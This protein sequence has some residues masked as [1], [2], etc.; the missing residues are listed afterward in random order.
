VNEHGNFDLFG[1]GHGIRHFLCLPWHLTAWSG[2]F[3]EDNA[4]GLLEGLPLLCLPLTMLWWERRL[5][6]LL[7]L[8]AC[9]LVAGTFLWFRQAQYLR[10]LLP[11]VP[12]MALLA[13]INAGAV[14]A[15]IGTS[16]RSRA[17]VATVAL[18][19]GLCWFQGTRW[20]AAKKNAMHGYPCLLVFGLESSEE[21]LRSVLAEYDPLRYLAAQSDEHATRVLAYPRH[22]RL[23]GG[24]CEFYYRAV[25][26][27]P[28][29]LLG[30]RKISLA[31]GTE[32]AKALAATSIDYLLLTYDYEYEVDPQYPGALMDAP[33]LD[34][35][36]RLIMTR[37]SWDHRR[38]CLYQF[39]R[40]AVDRLSRP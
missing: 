17:R 24:N 34:K 7:W 1:F 15:A 14:W 32:I 28:E 10:Y 35:Y 33:F 21:H 38:A 22:Q 40:E 11:M 13:G 8:P 6:R 26:D 18:L 9:V 39:K 27:K 30:A 16:A 4:W 12:L 20:W 31:D 2:K 29:L 19:I 25:S 37:D 23:Y 5:W 36:C 3:G